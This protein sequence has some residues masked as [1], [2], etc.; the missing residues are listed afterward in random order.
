MSVIEVTNGDVNKAINRLRKES[1]KHLAEIKHRYLCPK[2]SE[3]RRAKAHRAW[4][5]KKKLDA[6][7]AKNRKRYLARR[8]GKTL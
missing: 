3:R 2:Q 7:A 1:G 5:R 8:K 4:R 6:L